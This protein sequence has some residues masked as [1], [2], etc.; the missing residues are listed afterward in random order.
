MKRKIF[1]IILTF[2]FTFFSISQ[3]K[4]Q[5]DTDFDIDP[6]IRLGSINIPFFDQPF[7]SV[8][9]YYTFFSW[10]S[11]VGTL[12][13]FGIV[14]YWIY[15]VLRAAFD[16][17]KSEGEAEKLESSFS[18]IK[19]AFIG[20]SI[21]L[22]FPILLTTLGFIFGLGPLWSWP[23]G[24]RSCPNNDESVFFFQEVLRQ[25]DA[26]AEDPVDEAEIVCY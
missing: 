25:A 2:A 17:L 14:A 11:F 6:N 1:I 23:K 9:Q 20:A 16:A 3:V 12:L 15:L 19:S 26:G 24:F 13:S 22:V 21:A 5:D 10:A 4:A 8:D 18:E 7:L